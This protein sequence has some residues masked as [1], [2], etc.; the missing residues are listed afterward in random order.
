MD[1]P[2]AAIDVGTNTVLLLIARKDS[3]GL[4]VPVLDVQRVPRL[5]AGVDAHKKLQPDAMQRVVAVLA[6]YCS[7]ADSH[8]VRKILACATSAVRDAVNRDEFVAQ[9][10]RFTG[11]RLEV[12]SGEEEALW[13]YQGAISGIPSIHACLVLDIGGG[14][15]EMI[16]GNG[17][18]IVS[19]VSLDIGAVRLTERCFVHDPPL[20]TEIEHASELISNA[21]TGVIQRTDPDSQLIAVAGTP[22]AL[23]T[24]TL[25]LPD[26]SREAVA[27]FV[28][29]R[30]QI[31]ELWRRLR[32][33]PSVDIRKLSNVMEGRADVIIAGTL[34]LRKVMDH[35]GLSTMTVSER[36]LR[37]GLALRALKPD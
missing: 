11:L 19:R 27:G 29:K 10:Q 21:L 36:G 26:Y 32:Q 18:E 17:R 16:V 33:L 22:N 37:Y 24:L 20:Q 34:I 15:T 25:E 23:A 2:V 28:M 1:R 6:D 9:V 30:S 31:E 14:S 7:I 3:G 5:G 13:S 35:F 8:G 4:L 12:L